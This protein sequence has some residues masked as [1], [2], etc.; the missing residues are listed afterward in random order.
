MPPPARKPPVPCLRN[1]G[2][3]PVRTES[4]SLRYACVT[5][6]HNCWVPRASRRRRPPTY[7][8]L[9]TFT[10]L[11]RRRQS[12]VLPPKR[13][14]APSRKTMGQPLLPPHVSVCPQLDPT[15]LLQHCASKPSQPGG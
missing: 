3:E 4:K 6:R 10:L 8:R 1:D 13:P 2:E 15:D 12:W 11:S 5:A 14:C 7:L 9:S